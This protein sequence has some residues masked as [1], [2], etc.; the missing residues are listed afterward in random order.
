[1]GAVSV[2]RDRIMSGNQAAAPDPSMLPATPHVMPL[3]L[4]EYD[5][6]NSFY[7]E[8]EPAWSS[9]A[10]T[11]DVNAVPLAALAHRSMGAVV[12]AGRHV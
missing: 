6:M 9:A 4:I 11:G 7:N 8:L 1:M 5:G 10:S 12:P 3:A 2:L